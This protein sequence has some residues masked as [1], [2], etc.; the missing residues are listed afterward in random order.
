MRLIQDRGRKSTVVVEIG[1]DWL[2]ILESRVLRS[3]KYLTA[4]GFMKLAH[5]R[6]KVSDEI[7]KI[8]KDL[9]LDKKSVITYIPRHLLTVR[10]MHLP[11]TDPKEISDMVNLQVG[12]QTPY[13]K[14]EIISSHKILE[15]E[16]EGYT[17]VMLVIA[18]R[19]IISERLETLT[20]AGVKVKKVAVSSEGVYEWFNAAYLTEAGSEVSS[21]RQLVVIDIDSNYSDFI[22]IRKGK[23]AFTRNIFIG[24]NHLAETGSGWYDKF[25]EELKHSL[26]LYRNS[27]SREEISKI[28]LSGATKNLP[29]LESFVSAKLDMPAESAG[30]LKNMRVKKGARSLGDENNFKFISISP[31]IG[32]AMKGDDIALD[33]TTSESRIQKVM[34]ENRK[35]LMVT[36]VLAAAIALTVSFV[37]LTFV[38]NKVAYLREVKKKIVKIEPNAREVGKMRMRISLIE[39]RLDAKGASINILNEIYKLIPREIYLTGINIHEKRELILKGRADEMSDVFRFITTLENSGMFTNVKTSYTTTKKD[40]NTEYADFEIICLY[41]EAQIE[42]EAESDVS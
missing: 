14:D 36:G 26:N 33:L 41:E 35:S 28:F 40:G 5:T 18:R 21:H 25:A 37:F 23:L 11:S 29:D 4:A 8:F 12:K 34:E 6:G 38:H 3:Q 39:K 32:I 16:R 27:E 31:L 13:S 22:V 24:A 30:A 2:K 42:R 1:N 10:V 20:G 15:S 17:G 19:N 7:A 9:N